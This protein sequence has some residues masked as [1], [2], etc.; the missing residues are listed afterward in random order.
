MVVKT[1]ARLE[2][3]QKQDLGDLSETRLAVLSPNDRH[4]PALKKP[5]EPPLSKG[6]KSVGLECSP[7]V[8]MSNKFP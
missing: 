7:G 6:F 3:E 2:S 5:S 1:Q 8:Y 4:S